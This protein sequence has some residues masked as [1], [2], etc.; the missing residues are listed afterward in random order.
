M[1]YKDDPEY[2]EQMETL[3]ADAEST[4]CLIESRIGEPNFFWLNDE[5]NNR[6]I[7][8]RWDDRPAGK[9]SEQGNITIIIP[10]DDDEKLCQMME[11][12]END[13]LLVPL[14]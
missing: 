12:A 9:W 10:N 7:L 2:Q 4:G 1:T 14:V 3:C 6:M 5:D 11:R 8:G 13:L